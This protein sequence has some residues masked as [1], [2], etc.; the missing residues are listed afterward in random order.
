MGLLAVHFYPI[1]LAVVSTAALVVTSITALCNGHA[2]AGD[3]PYVTDFAA[4]PP[5]SS[6]FAMFISAS[7]ML[8]A[9]VVYIRYKEVRAFYRVHWVSISTNRMNKAGLYIG[10]TMSLAFLVMAC[11]PAGQEPDVHYVAAFSGF[12]LGIL[13]FI[14]QVVLAFE[15]TR[16]IG[17][18]CI[19]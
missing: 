9:S 2:K 10:W 14:L 17:N 13:Y 5:E 8:V 19:L 1:I 12:G 16:C 7:S 3:W 15:E 11:F 18:L 6:I 4:R